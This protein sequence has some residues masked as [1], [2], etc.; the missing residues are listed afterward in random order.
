M[1]GAVGGLSAVDVDITDWVATENLVEAGTTEH[2]RF[3][4]I[5]NCA[6]APP[7]EFDLSELE[8]RRHYYEQCIEINARGAYHLYEAAWRAGGVAGGLHRQHDRR[9]GPAALRADQP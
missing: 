8:G 1:G 9:A 2:E 4:A 5:V 3:D 7:R 6:I